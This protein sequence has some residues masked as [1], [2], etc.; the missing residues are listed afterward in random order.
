MI[1]CKIRV[2]EHGRG[3]PLPAYQT[4]GSAAMDLLA[5][6]EDELRLPPGE[7]LLVPTGLQFAVPQGHELQIRPRSG[8]ALK[9]GL[10]V[11]NSPG[12]IDS[13]YRGEVQVILGN[14]GREDFCITRGMRICQAAL[15][16]V[17]QARLLPVDELD[18]TRRGS[19]GFGHTGR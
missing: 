12:T 19:G 2:L 5:A 14:L 3:L 18:E 7:I 13:D 11:P 10:I 9:H 1:D 17:E 8:L 4:P 16:K 6:V 15:V